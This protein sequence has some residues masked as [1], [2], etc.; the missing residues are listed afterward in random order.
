MS[1]S[2]DADERRHG[3]CWPAFESV[4]LAAVRAVDERPLRLVIPRVVSEGS[5]WSI[6]LQPEHVTELRIERVADLTAVVGSELQ[7]GPT[8]VWPE[9]G[10]R[11]PGQLDDSNRRDVHEATLD[12]CQPGDESE[13][14]V[15]VLPSGALQGASSRSW[16]TDIFSRWQPLEVILSRELLHDVA[17][18]VE[19][20]AVVLRPRSEG[21]KP[22]R[23]FRLPPKVKDDVVIADHDRLLTREGGSTDYGYVIRKALEPDARISF[24]AHDPA[25]DVRRNRIRQFGPTVRL[26]DLYESVPGPR[27]HDEQYPGGSVRQL[28]GRDIGRNGELLAADGEEVRAGY[29]EHMHLRPGD[30]VVREIYAPGRS[31]GVAVAQVRA[32]DLPAVPGRGVIAL[33][34][35]ADL[36][37][38]EALFIV[39][40]LGSAAAHVLMASESSSLAGSFRLS[41]QILLDLEVPRPSQSLL[42]SLSHLHAARALFDEWSAS[43]S[44]V[45]GSLFEASDADSAKSR[46]IETG[47]TLRLRAESARG[48]DDLPSI[49][50]TR[51]PHPVA[52]RWRS[53]E[54]ELSHGATRDG[55][56]AVLE[57]AEV[58]LAYAALVGLA[59]AR[60][61]SLTVKATTEVQKKLASGRSG[62]S[63]GDWSNILEELAN[64]RALARAPGPI[65]SFMRTFLV[66][67]SAAHAARIRLGARRND[68]SHLRYPTGGEL[69][70]AVEEV[71]HDLLVLMRSAE[72]LSDLPLLHL[73]EV[74]WDSLEERSHVRYRALMGDHS[75]VPLRSRTFGVAGLEQGSLYLL[76]PDGELRLARPFLIGR[77]CPTCGNWSTFHIDTAPEGRVELKSL[78]RG[79]VLPD[80]DRSS[81]EAVGLL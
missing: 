78:E 29:P 56:D 28:S 30:L 76:D 72:F 20:A 27:V 81:A 35:R 26:R 60:H 3:R 14:L 16:R 58:L 6:P 65:M 21:W 66:N 61:L 46:L 34:P 32:E 64:S 39:T 51:F 69:G 19:I 5:D 57:C 4:L 41:P 63:F 37:D 22:L 7:L 17:P 55:L 12:A 77:N 24:E 54:A 42:T 48:M 79:H 40:L 31:G 13:C 23:M 8:V 38:D 75:V 36:P 70:A 18:S 43:A 49:I 50:R 11:V 15:I 74:R 25:V 68:A 2:R 80:E 33:R 52:F 44:D 71:E 67:E 9:W 45:L 10:R 47:R 62:P 73:T 59:E 53:A 1:E